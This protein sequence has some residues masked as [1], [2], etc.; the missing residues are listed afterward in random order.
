MA[1][2]AAEVMLIFGSASRQIPVPNLLVIASRV[3]PGYRTGQ[4]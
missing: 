2:E 3:T 4:T 1:I